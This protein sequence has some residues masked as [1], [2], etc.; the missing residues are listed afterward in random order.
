MYT[1][2][3]ADTLKPLV[4]WMMNPLIEAGPYKTQ[5]EAYEDAKKYKL[6]PN[7]ILLDDHQYALL[8]NKSI[9]RSMF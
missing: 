7:L 6:H 5:I 4:F 8:A 2:Y 9:N 1:F 3:F